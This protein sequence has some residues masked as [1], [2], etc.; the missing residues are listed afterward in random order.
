[1]F[2]P[3]VCTVTSTNIFLIAIQKLSSRIQEP[4]SRAKFI[5]DNYGGNYLSIL[6]SAVTASISNCHHSFC[7]MQLLSHAL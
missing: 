4:L 5:C 7:G 3:P 6:L 2:S 1:M